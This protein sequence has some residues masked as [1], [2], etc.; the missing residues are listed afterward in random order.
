MLYLSNGDLCVGGLY[1]DIHLF[2][3]KSFQIKQK[4]Q[5]KHSSY[6]KS[7]IELNSNEI[8]SSSDDETI[9]IWSKNNN[10]SNLF[11]LFKI[12]N[13]HSDYVWDLIKI[14]NDN[15]LLSFGS[16]SRDKTIILWNKQ[17]KSQIKLE[18]SSSLFCL[19]FLEDTKELIAGSFDSCILIFN[20][21]EIINK[22]NKNPKQIINTKER[23]V[24]TLC[25]INKTTFAS[26]HY[27]GSILIHKL[28]SNNNIYELIQKIKESNKNI[29]K[30]IYIKRNHLLIS[31]CY[32]ENKINIFQLKKEKEE[33]FKLK[34]TLQHKEVETLVEM[35]NE[36]FLSGGYDKNIKIWHL[37]SSSSSFSFF[38]F[39]S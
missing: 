7:L 3:T 4:F 36:I 32:R 12:L 30:L 18:Y 24:F 25:K 39:F 19:L 34:E 33:E 1:G 6:V 27:N 15:D 9:I 14:P 21:N 17:F 23:Y 37:S 16:C 11:E 20:L 35:S 2:E 22:N 26:G 10:N 8:I 5:K 31:C 13:E 29:S 28:N 38:S